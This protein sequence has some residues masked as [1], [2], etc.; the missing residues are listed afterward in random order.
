MLDVYGGGL[1]GY[2]KDWLKEHLSER[3]THIFGMLA[4]V[5][6]SQSQVSDLS[7]IENCENTVL[8]LKPG[9]F[10]LVYQEPKRGVLRSFL[11]RL[12]EVLE[13]SLPQDKRGQY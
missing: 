2:I 13:P 10:L 11:A 3:H 4:M 1:W 6:L 12:T 9:V 7:S 5:R 8:V